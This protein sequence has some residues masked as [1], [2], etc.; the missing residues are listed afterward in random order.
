MKNLRVAD[1]SVMPKIVTGNTAT[2]AM[3]IGEKAA[4]MI[5]ETIQCEDYHYEYENDHH[6]QSSVESTSFAE[7][8]SSGG[9]SSFVES[10]TFSKSKSS[11]G[12]SSF[13]ESKAFDESKSS[14]GGSSFSESKASSKS[15]SS[16]GGS[17]FAESKAFV[18]SKSS[19]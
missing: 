8:K 18:E 13:S 12:G 3:M 15:K 11:D 9:G 10:K 6:Q 4:D 5:K 1:V 14:G 19:D 7:S 17:S 16:G 2:A